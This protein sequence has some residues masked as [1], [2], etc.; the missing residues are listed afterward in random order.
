MR[1]NL[2]KILCP[3]DFSPTSDHAIRYAVTLA[4]SFDAELLLLHVLDIPP[5]SACEYYGLSVPVREWA[6]VPPPYS[7]GSSE[8]ERAEDGTYGERLDD[9]SAE[10]DSEPLYEPEESQDCGLEQLAA[11]LRESHGG[12]ITTCLR[13]GRAFVEIVTAAREETVDLIVIGTHGRTGLAH[14]LIGS[15]AERVVRTAPCPV[16]TVKHPEHEFVMP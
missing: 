14:M 13:E 1:I 2:K 8:G 12:R 6:T 3:V 11:R 7:A 16:L 9:A 4:E 10:E 15:T 5:A